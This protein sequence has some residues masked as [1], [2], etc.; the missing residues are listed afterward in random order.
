MIFYKQFLMACILLMVVGTGLVACNHKKLVE[1]GFTLS[2]S[3]PVLVRGAK[4]DWDGARI[5]P[6]GM[7]YHDGQFHMI[8]NAFSAWPGNVEMGYAVSSDGIHWEKQGEGPVLK[9]SDVDYAQVAASASSLLVEDDG[10]W[11]LYFHV[12]QTRSASLGSGFIGR[13]TA[14]QPQGPWTVEAEPV[15]RMSKNE[16]AWDGGQV[17]QA[18]VHKTENGYLMYYTGADKKGYM[19]IGLATSANGIDW[20][21]HDDPAST[22][23]LYAN[24]DPLLAPKSGSWESNGIYQSRVVNTPDGWIMIY[25][26]FGF[27]PQ[28]NALGFAISEDGVDWVKVE[29][30]PLIFPNIVPGQGGFGQPSLLYERDRYWLYAESLSLSGSA[31]IFLINNEAPI[32]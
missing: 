21:K 30:N 2:T 15:L 11:V 8:F 9:T 19:R 26:T 23:A 13:A 7:V 22:E 16:D 6:G 12:W 1:T 5:D 3:D 14:S 25:K 4:G 31:G 10:T 32:F 29:Q 18:N 27:L 24:S 28:N 20:D 17:S